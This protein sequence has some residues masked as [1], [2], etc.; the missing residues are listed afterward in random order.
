VIPA[1][2]GPDLDEGERVL[3]PLRAFGP[4]AADLVARMPYVSMQQMFDAT[5]PFGIRSYWKS[6]FLQALPDEAIDTFVHCA[7]AR[8]SPRT[9][10][11]LEHA[12]GAVS[13][14]APDATAFPARGFAFDL[15]VLSLWD[16]AEDDARNVAWT[17]EFDRAM[18]PWSAPLVYVN[19]LGDDDR[20]RVR[21]AYG[22]NYA[23]LVR[24]KTTYDPANR[25]RRNQ[26]IAPASLR[27]H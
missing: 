23:R 19:A 2:S 20:G 15:V 10:V 12:H 1:Y 18:H 25:F 4:P 7:S 8:A 11:K 17:R 21:E 9:V 27:V 26:N 3:A 16:D 22:D 6:R 14:V 24:V 5:T 13:R